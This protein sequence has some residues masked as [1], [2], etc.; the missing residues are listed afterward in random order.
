[1]DKKTF[2]VISSFDKNI[3]DEIDIEKLK[4]AA[5]ETETFTKEQIVKREMDKIHKYNKIK[6][7]AVNFMP[8]TTI[9]T[10]KVVGVQNVDD[11]L[12]NETKAVDLRIQTFYAEESEGEESAIDLFKK[13]LLPIIE[14]PVG[15]ELFFFDGKEN[16]GIRRIPYKGTVK[17]VDFSQQSSQN[18]VVVSLLFVGDLIDTTTNESSSEIATARK[19][20]A[21]A[22]PINYG[23]SYEQGE[24]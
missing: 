21:T 1:M 14:M 13:D 17:S 2:C 6:I 11:I 22:T 9:G 4:L 12:S 24:D 3:K 20:Q 15:V 7:S 23:M 8:K 5:L 18:I 10:F 19:T 16:G